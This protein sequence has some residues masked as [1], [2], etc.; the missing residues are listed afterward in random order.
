MNPAYYR[1]RLLCDLFWNLLLPVLVLF[2]V[3]SQTQYRLGFL[4][5]PAY[6]A[7][8]F[9]WGTT[10]D[11]YRK[12]MQE[13]EAKLL[14]A[15]LIPCIAGKWPGNIDVLLNMMRAFKS[16]YILDVYLQLFEEYQCTTI[17]TRILWSDTVGIAY[18]LSRFRES[19][20]L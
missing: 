14:G 13:K 7:F 18:I 15:R 10:K 6:V 19:R 4:S 8:I 3:L 20:A 1:V 5:L 11:L 12:S 17:N 2:L 16:S 9:L